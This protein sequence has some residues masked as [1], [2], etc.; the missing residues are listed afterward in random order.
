MFDGQMSP[1]AWRQRAPR[2][3][4]SPVGPQ[5]QP[6][7]ATLDRRW[8]WRI[9]AFLTF[10]GGP[11]GYRQLSR[12][13]TAYLRES[14]VH[15]WDY[16]LGCGDEPIRQCLWCNVVETVAAVTDSSSGEGRI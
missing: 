10:N 3:M 5:G 14:C 6:T 8:L 15:D 1:S 4:L 13:L 2:S 9:E 16:G 7:T 11:S 12:D